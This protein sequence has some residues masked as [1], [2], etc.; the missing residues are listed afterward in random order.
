MYRHHH[1]LDE[2][3]EDKIAQR[4]TAGLV[5][6]AV[7]LLLLVS[8]LFLVQQLRAAAMLQDCLMSGRHYCDVSVNGPH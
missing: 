4:Q 8:G 6:I 2:D 7:V 1:W 5:G 3:A